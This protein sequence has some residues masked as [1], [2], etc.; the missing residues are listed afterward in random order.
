MSTSGT[1]KEPNRDRLLDLLR[2]GLIS[3][4]EFEDLVTGQSST[5]ETA[6]VTSGERRR[7][8]WPF[9]LA[10]LLV[11]AATGTGAFVLIGSDGDT[12][13]GSSSETTSPPTTPTTSTPPEPSSAPDD[14]QGAVE[15]TTIRTVDITVTDGSNRRSFPQGFA[16]RF[17][18]SSTGPSHRIFPG[19]N[20]LE[21]PEDEIESAT[22]NRG[23]LWVGFEDAS[24]DV[25][26]DAFVRDS[27]G[28]ELNV[29]LDDREIHVSSSW[30]EN[31]SLDRPD[32]LNDPEC[33]IRF[34]L[35]FGWDSY[36][37][38][39]FSLS[40][41]NDPSADNI[42]RVAGQRIPIID[43]MSESLRTHIRR[44]G[45]SNLGE[46][47][48]LLTAVEALRDV[49]SRLVNASVD[50]I[51]PLINELNRLVSDQDNA[52]ERVRSALRSIC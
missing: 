48:G 10:V 16:I 27:A 25:M 40:W 38:N 11:L 36:I 49:H 15:E 24:G 6:L 5:G 43:G 28:S 26:K 47:Q 19:P 46:V 21:V 12:E 7:R 14:D 37:S 1:P 23:G 29:R 41:N 8:R 4:A 52:V 2:K 18:P 3:E 20:R 17:S 9:A 44:H 33:T 50:Q 34:S 45:T 30:L 32:R 13:E 51:N 31:F 22:N 42:R 39:V 35:S